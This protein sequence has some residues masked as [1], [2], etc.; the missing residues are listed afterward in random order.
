MRIT[1]AIIKPIL[2]EKSLAEEQ[3]GRYTFLV[4]KHATAGLVKNEIKK[5]YGVDVVK[6]RTIILPGKPKRLAKTNRFKSTPS[7]KKMIV[8]LKKG[9]KIEL[10]VKDSKGK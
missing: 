7:R 9:Q 5:M 4:N 10:M 8:A 6:V 1:S 2:S 3:L